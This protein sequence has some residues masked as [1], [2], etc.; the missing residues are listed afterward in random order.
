MGWCSATRIFDGVIE[1]ALKTDISDE[2]LV[3]V[4]TSLYQELTDMDWDCQCESEFFNHPRIKP[5]I[6]KIENNV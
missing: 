2:A 4:V 3:A 1:S 5:I 6:D